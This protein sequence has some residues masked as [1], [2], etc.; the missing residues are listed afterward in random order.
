MNNNNN[1]WIRPNV[2]SWRRDLP[3]RPTS[4]NVMNIDHG[5][6]MMAI[7]PD[8]ST[9]SSGDN[10]KPPAC[11]TVKQIQVLPYQENKPNRPVT[12][13]I[14]RDDV[15]LN[16]NESYASEHFV[17][18]SSPPKND[19]SPTIVTNTINTGSEFRYWQICLVNE[20]L[21]FLVS[22]MIVI[23]L[24][25]CC[26]IFRTTTTQPLRLHKKTSFTIINELEPHQSRP[27]SPAGGRVSPFRGKGFRAESSKRFSRPVSCPES[28]RNSVDVETISAHASHDD[29]LLN[30]SNKPS[31]HFNIIPPIPRRRSA[32][33]VIDA[34]TTDE[35]FNS[36]ESFG[37]ASYHDRDMESFEIVSNGHVPSGNLGRIGSTKIGG[38]GGSGG[39][40]IGSGKPSP[41]PR[42]HIQ[43][44][45]SSLNRISD[46]D[47]DAYFGQQQ[48][49]NPRSY[50]KGLLGV[51][52]GG[53]GGGG[54]GGGGNTTVIPSRIPRRK[55]SISTPNISRNSSIASA[56]RDSRRESNSSDRFGMRRESSVS[57]RRHLRVG[58]NE[59]G[60]SLIDLGMASSAIRSV[61]RISK[62]SSL[63]PI[64][65]TPNKDLDQD[66]DRFYGN[67][68]DGMHDSKYGLDSPTKI[69]VRRSSSVNVHGR[70]LS[71]S[72]GGSRLNSREASPMKSPLKSPSNRKPST[73]SSSMNKSP[74]KIPQ[75]I[76][77]SSPSKSAKG[78]DSSKSVRKEASSARK[79]PSSVKKAPSATAKREP[80]TLK[81][82]NSQQ[83]LKRESSMIDIGGGGGGSGGSRPAK[84]S[85]TRRT[86]P[87]AGSLAKNQSDSSLTKRLE[88]KNS[89]KQKRRTSSESDGL[90]EIDTANLSDK[91]TPLTTTLDGV[92]MTTALVASQPVQITTAVTD[93]LSKKNSSG[94]IVNNDNSVVN[95]DNSSINNISTS[96]V[97]EPNASGKTE[98][99]NGGDGSAGTPVT[100][101]AAAAATTSASSATITTT[102]TTTVIEATAP[103]VGGNEIAATA[104]SVNLAT[105]K[106]TDTSA[107]I[108]QTT[109]SEIVLESDNAAAA[110]ANDANANGN[111]S[112]VLEKKAS[113]RTLGGKSETG[114]AAAA[115]LG[116]PIVPES[117]ERELIGTP[118]ET[119]VNVIDK[120][121]L[122]GTVEN[123]ALL[124]KP[125][126]TA[127]LQAHQRNNTSAAGGGGGMSRTHENRIIETMEKDN[128][129]TSSSNIDPSN[130][131]KNEM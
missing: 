108:S 59:F 34:T 29:S 124:M 20:M 73:S 111:S 70:T 131:A 54:A 94:Q 9:P 97:S 128:G 85:A 53:G 76:N 112:A 51:V 66:N 21:L 28:P 106:A 43:R 61:N 50:H 49:V 36:R 122:I 12:A 114:S 80:S 77:G 62:P 95:N 82:Q 45:A 115:A 93:H 84:A 17:N 27:A 65:G 87:T 2:D 44:S 38:G 67:D 74:T 25:F 15:R 102:T 105:A 69:P 86:P 24:H 91:L 99:A 104:S 52:S 110:A 1:E 130:G 119:K 120:N 96:N 116:T 13:A 75:K 78:Q 98:V 57:P 19:I 107:T 7:L 121:S 46:L 10:Q 126:D 92:S 55:S 79:E 64:V 123:E 37:D 48:S 68:Y 72:R 14:H 89:F 18:S 60:G 90:N 4:R 113:T 23:L 127:D 26:F 33:Q 40:A 129:A 109:T 71:T 42:Q 58:G 56:R 118:I 16:S 100:T 63:S 117:I 39:S 88:K 3:P 22:M 103:I 8:S 83:K 30:Q 35:N 31:V 6:A 5:S 41:A 81:R 32:I 101:A 125:N 47:S 11:P